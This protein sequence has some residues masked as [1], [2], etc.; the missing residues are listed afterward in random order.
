MMMDQQTTMPGDMAGQSGRSTMI[1]ARR[2]RGSGFQVLHLELC[3]RHYFEEITQFCCFEH[4]YNILTEIKKNKFCFHFHGAVKEFDH[5]TY[6]GRIY[7]LDISTVNCH[8]F[9]PPGKLF[10]PYFLRV[11]Y[12]FYIKLAIDIQYD[13]FA[14]IFARN[15]NHFIPHA[16]TMKY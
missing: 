16:V 3:P 7:V 8:Y 12:T 13:D 6:S 11:F 9:R 4:A 1:N 2:V 5:D 10:I 14:V 15:R